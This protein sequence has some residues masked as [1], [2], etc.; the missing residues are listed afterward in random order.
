MTKEQMEQ[1][2]ITK[3]ELEEYEHSDKLKD[4]AQQ[5]KDYNISVSIDELMDDRGSTSARI[6]RP[7]RMSRVKNEPPMGRRAAIEHTK[8]KNAEENNS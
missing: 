5:M 2:M 1:L 4:Y 3:E 8:K 7:S 6:A